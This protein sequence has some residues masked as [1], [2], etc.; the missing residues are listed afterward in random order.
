[1]LPF[2]L[3]SINIIMRL[4]E[5]TEAKKEQPPKAG[6]TTPH[7][8]NYGWERLNFLRSEAKKDGDRVAGSYQLFIPRG[9]RQHTTRNISKDMLARPW[10]WDDEGNLKPE[11]EKYYDTRKIRGEYHPSGKLDE[12]AP[13][14]NP[15]KIPPIPGDNKPRG[16]YFWTSTGYKIDD[17]WSSDW[18][19]FITGSHPDWQNDIGYLYKV[20]PGALI[21]ELDSDH[22]AER[23]YS[24]FQGLDRVKEKDYAKDFDYRSN[25]RLSFP[26]DQISK[27]FDAVRHSRPYGHTEFMYGWDVESTVWFDTSFLQL[28]GEVPVAGWD[29]GD[30]Y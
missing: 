26:W 19:R 4:H 1:M 21:L 13:I 16:A 20:K 17:K 29:T 9:I 25:M 8:Y 27:N 14:L 2:F 7:D 15:S 23:I 28:V 30:D 12:A 5:F 22:D 6:D 10:A 24:A 18:N 11:Y 3:V